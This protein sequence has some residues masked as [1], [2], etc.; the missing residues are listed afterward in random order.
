ML[1]HQI[2]NIFECLFIVETALGSLNLSSYSKPPLFPEGDEVP[3]ALRHKIYRAMMRSLCTLVARP[4]RC[5]PGLHDSLFTILT[6][7]MVGFCIGSE[8]CFANH[9]SMFHFMYGRRDCA[10][11]NSAPAGTRNVTEVKLAVFRCR[12]RPRVLPL[13]APYVLVLSN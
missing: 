9:Y 4:S 2:T 13:T 12:H 8:T 3:H 7:V 11:R 1:D 5:S 6:Y 10:P